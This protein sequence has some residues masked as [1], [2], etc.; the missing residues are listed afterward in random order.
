MDCREAVYSNDY[1]DFIAEYGQVRG[2]SSLGPC[3][4]NINE[5]FSIAFVKND[6]EQQYN[7]RQFSYLA[8]PALYAP[9]DTG[10]L[11][12]SGILR[13]QGQPT[14]SLNG[15]GV[16]VGFLDSGIDYENKVFR[17]TDG[18]SRIEAIWDQTIQTGIPPD[19]FLYG[20]EY[21]Q[22]AI[23]LALESDTPT[24][25]VPSVDATGHGTFVAS[26]ASGGENTENNF[27]GAAP[28]SKIAMVKLKEAKQYIKDF[29]FVGD[30]AVVYQENDIMAAI[31]YLNKL[32]LELNL[33]L[34]ICI[35]FGT[36]MGG[37]S[38]GGPLS[39]LL[40]QIVSLNMRA[41]VIGAGNEA[42][43]RHHFY[44]EGFEEGK[45]ENVE[46]N[47]G[48]DV[49]GFTA[50]LWARPPDLY[51]I[52][53]VSP[54][55]ER[56][57]KIPLA[58]ETSTEYNFVFENTTVTID[59]RS[60]T[61]TGDQLI[62]MRFINPTA[63]L[64]NVRV[65]GEA[66]IQGRFHIWLPMT[67]FHS[68]E[69]FFIRSDPEVTITSPGSEENAITVGAY[70][71]ADN[72]LY[73]NSGRGFTAVGTVKPEDGVIIGKSCRHKMLSCQPLICYNIT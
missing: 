44:K 21:R 3:V 8:I 49:R 33:P 7:V 22:S 43:Q 6:P 34:I 18:T 2:L 60:D 72:S 62:F 19:G 13:I 67:A 24:Q 23:N 10:A 4:Q 68:G 5:Q 37:H 71:S 39:L 69:V 26:V 59:Y 73:L 51:S 42:A 35:S 11:E 40:T 25:V 63:G 36:N 1:W 15:Q 46:V 53:I 58:L 20:A 47:V 17:N 64:W 12:A 61:P 28:Y 70:N 38:G 30:S 27:I 29:Y 55:G 16:L 65:Y 48:Q 50:E 9:I 52:E 54:T 66:V 45:F 57:P 56:G 32:A 41:I 14:L 31:V